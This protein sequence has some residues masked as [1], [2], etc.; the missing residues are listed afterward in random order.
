MSVPTSSPE[1]EEWV[2]SRPP[3]V[4][5]LMAEFAMGSHYIIDGELHHLIGFTE[6]DK[7]ILSTVDPAEDYDGAL[8]ARVY[9]CAEHVRAARPTDMP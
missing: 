8:D 7:L 4:Q 3:S 1:F 2:A 9:L 6:D 5:A